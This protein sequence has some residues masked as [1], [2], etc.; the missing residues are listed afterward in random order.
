MDNVSVKKEVKELHETLSKFNNRKY[1]LNLI[2]TNQRPSLNKTRLSFKSSRSQVK[3][4]I[5]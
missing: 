2:L 4:Y 5:G 3:A 1:N